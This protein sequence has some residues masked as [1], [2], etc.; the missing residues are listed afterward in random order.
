[1][2]RQ[3]LSEA[4]ARRRAGLFDHLVLWAHGVAVR[5]DWLPSEFGDAGAVDEPDASAVRREWL[6]HLRMWADSS[7]EQVFAIK[8]GGLMLGGTL[9]VLVLLIAVMD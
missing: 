4:P 5:R 1:M 9:A 2:S 6:R 3:A 7:P 8:A